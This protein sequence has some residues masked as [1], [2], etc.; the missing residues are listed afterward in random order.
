M[1]F[2]EH[3]GAGFGLKSGFDDSVPSKIRLHESE[4]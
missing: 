1:A 2:L 4:Y 3:Q